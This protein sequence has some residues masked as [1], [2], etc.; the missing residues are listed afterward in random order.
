M[1]AGD[2]A[3]CR[4]GLGKMQLA[5]GV[6]FK[7]LETPMDGRTFR[8]LNQ[9]LGG[10]GRS[11]AAPACGTALVTGQ[12]PAARRTLP[13]NGLPGLL[14]VG[15]AKTQPGRSQPSMPVRLRNG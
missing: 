5:L 8:N 13:S 4:A 2:V 12:A 15:L 7:P 1:V 6:I 9:V 10:V 11:S 14:G 3:R